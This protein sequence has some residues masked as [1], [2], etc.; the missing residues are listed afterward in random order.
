LNSWS[1]PH[2]SGEICST[3]ES[4]ACR[5]V[6]R[7]LTPPGQAEIKNMQVGETWWLTFTEMR[8]GKDWECYLNPE[9]AERGKGINRILVTRKEDGFHVMVADDFPFVDITTEKDFIPVVSVEYKPEKKK[10]LSNE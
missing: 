9:A 5:Q 8:L 1:S 7:T 6:T 10:D 2:V 4:H 3:L